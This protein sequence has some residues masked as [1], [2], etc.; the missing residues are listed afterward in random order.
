MHNVGPQDVFP[1]PQGIWNY[2]G[3]NTLAINVWSQEDSGEVKVDGLSLVTGP[4]IQSGYGA[5]E[6]APQP[7]WTKRAGAY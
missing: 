6:A 7:A 1:V 2:Q 3:K 5:I 4:I